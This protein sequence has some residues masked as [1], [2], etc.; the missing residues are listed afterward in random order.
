MV[1]QQP[2]WRIC[3][4]D[5]VI[6]NS[7]YDGNSDIV[8]NIGTVIYIGTSPSSRIAVEYPTKIWRGHRGLGKNGKH[9]HCWNIPP[10][11]LALHKCNEYKEKKR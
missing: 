2:F 6:A 9:G 7:S 8:N 4:G 10:R 5:K 1:R 11:R 3:L